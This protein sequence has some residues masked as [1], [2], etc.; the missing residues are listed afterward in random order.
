M[1]KARN[2][3]IAVVCISLL[4]LPVGVH[5]EGLPMYNFQNKLMYGNTMPFN[6]V[7]PDFTTIQDQEVAEKAQAIT[8]EFYASVLSEVAGDKNN[9]PE[10]TFSYEVTG[11]ADY[12]SV[13][14]HAETY[15]GNTSS[16]M[17]KTIVFDKFSP[18]IVTLEDVLGEGAYSAATDAVTQKINEN[19]DAY[20]SDENKFEEVTGLTDFYVS[21]GSGVFVLFDKYEIAPGAS[22]TPQFLIK[23]LNVN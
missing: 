9:L 6:G 5:A 7:L 14:L 15:Y 11:N 10:T 22:G 1:L 8:D 3:L 16:S 18:R 4:A 23:N 21:S 20:F 17:A 19:P 12:L 2:L 13:I